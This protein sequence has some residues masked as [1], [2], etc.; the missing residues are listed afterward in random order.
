MYFDRGQLLKLLKTIDFTHNILTL[1][2]TYLAIFYTQQLADVVL[3]SIKRPIYANEPSMPRGRLL[4]GF[5]E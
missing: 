4:H 2:I 1:F 5:G 3:V